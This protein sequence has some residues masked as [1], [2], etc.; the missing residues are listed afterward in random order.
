MILSTLRARLSDASYISIRVRFTNGVWPGF[1]SGHT[2]F[3]TSSVANLNGTHPHQW[4]RPRVYKAWQVTLEGDFTPRAS[5]VE[6]LIT[7]NGDFEF[8]HVDGSL[9]PVE[10]VQRWLK[11]VLQEPMP[12]GTD[13]CAIA[14]LMDLLRTQGVWV[15][16]VRRE[17]RAAPQLLVCNNTVCVWP[18]VWRLFYRVGGSS[19]VAASEQVLP[20]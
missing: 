14:G 19:R 7:H 9:H 15:T 13:S 3:A 16:S 18:E 12:S 20:L 8:F 17:P 1:G 4:C 11:L 5:N 2:R 10:S 6:A